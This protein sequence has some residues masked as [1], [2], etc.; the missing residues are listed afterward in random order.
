M[1]NTNGPKQGGQN[2]QPSGK[3][4]GPRAQP[5]NANGSVKKE[6]GHTGHGGGLEGHIIDCGQPKHA[7]LYNTTME[8]IV[9]YVRIEFKD[10]ELV[11]RTIAT[12]ARIDLKKP[13]KPDNADETDIEIWPAEIKD[14]VREKKSYKQALEHTYG[15]VWKQCT[16]NM[17]VNWKGLPMFKK[18]E[19]ASDL[20]ALLEGIKSLVFNFEA[21]K[22]LP[23]A[24]VCA[25]RNSYRYQQPKSMS[26]KEFLCKYKSFHEVIV[27]LGGRVGMHPG[28][29]AAHL[30][31]MGIDIQL[32]AEVSAKFDKASKKSEESNILH[33]TF[34]GDGL[35][36]ARGPGHLFVGPVW[37]LRFTKLIALAIAFKL[38]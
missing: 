9:N 15:L 11:S 21:T 3:L 33:A 26:D 38:D 4:S 36:Q 25:F 35:G 27:Q 37:I 13:E 18:M 5:I 14:F 2:N 32:D 17:K 24:L 23:E 8:E 6:S 12:G 29:I 16:Q 34:S 20:I 10:G 7:D 1:S 28:M 19:G 31:D 22:S 30:K